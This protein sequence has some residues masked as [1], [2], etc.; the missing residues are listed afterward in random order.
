MRIHI[1]LRYI[2][3][4][5]MAN[6]AFLAVSAAISA[7]NHEPAFLPLL[8]SALI[9]LLF[10][11]FPL[12]FVPPADQ[13]RND[14][15]LFI[16]VSSWLLSCLVGVLP[17]VLYGGEFTFTNAW[18]ES[19]SGFTT[20]GA[21]ILGDVEALPLGL[22]FWRASTH[23][24][25][26]IGII[27]F[28]LS[29]LPAISQ[30]AMVL[31]RTEI[32][33]LARNNFQYRTRETLHILLVVYV[34]LT[35]L[36]T[37]S[38]LACGMNLF[39][40]LAH[41][42]ATIATGGFGTRNLSVAHYGSVAVE[43]VIGLFMILSGIHFGLLFLAAR[44]QIGAIWKS[45]A[46]RC[47]LAALAVGSLLVT[48]SLHGGVYAGWAEAFR[49]ASFQVVSLGTSSGFATADS[50]GWPPFAMIVM[51]YFTLQ[52][53]CSGSTSG[54]IKVER[55]LLLLKAVRAKIMKLK[56][57]RAVVSLRLEGSFVNDEVLTAGL[58]FI[59]CYL[60]VIFLSTVLLAACGVDLLSG[61]SASAAAM[62]NVGPGFGSV[63][64]LSNY[65]ALPDAAKWVLTLVMLLGRLEIF[66]LLMFV[67][68]RT[69]K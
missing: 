26:G 23:W 11:V 50:A 52:C 53:A 29:V 59:C 25:G 62:G 40:A 4:V 12:I 15:G 69:L 63:S 51:I 14:E 30:A 32:S 8:Y 13:I 34:G 47:Y 49:Y 44:G 18:F 36:E 65:G 17:Y 45:T 41:S 3:V 31:S 28:V 1:I 39:D 55:V 20:T 37:V 35:L 16:V 61:F 27:V 68:S 58:L 38:L 60:A 46:V 5:A 64:S 54:G 57:P 21:S 7:W 33:P 10:G 6:G 56:H 19:V 22:L 67:S 42:F 48:L 2:G 9:S 66:G 43:S 24:I